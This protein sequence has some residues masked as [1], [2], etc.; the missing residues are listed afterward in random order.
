MEDGIIHIMLSDDGKG[1]D[2]S[3]TILNGGAVS[4]SARLENPDGPGS[5]YGLKNIVLRLKLLYG[6]EYGLSIES[7]CGKGTVIHLHIP[8]LTPGQVSAGEP[9]V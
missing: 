3:S 5:H 7:E 8:A 6:P 4:S 9:R 1:M 2:S